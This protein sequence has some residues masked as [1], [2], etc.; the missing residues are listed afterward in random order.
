MCTPLINIS[1]SCRAVTVVAVCVSGKVKKAIPHFAE[2][3]E[4]REEEVKKHKTQVV[5]TYSHEV[6]FH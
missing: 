6:T 2:W 4:R 3:Q 5:Y 1:S